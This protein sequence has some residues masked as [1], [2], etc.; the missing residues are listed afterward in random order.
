MALK[1]PLKTDAY[2]IGKERLQ[3][4]FAT[5]ELAGYF[6]NGET[7]LVGFNGGYELIDNFDIRV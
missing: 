1:E 7:W 4:P 5:V 6:G 3:P 2:V